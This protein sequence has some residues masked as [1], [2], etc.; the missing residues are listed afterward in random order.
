MIALDKI[1]DMFNAE[2]RNHIEITEKWTK[3]YN[4]GATS[5]ELFPLVIESHRSA[6][7]IELLNELIQAHF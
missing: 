1:N 4:N 2:S 6:A 5:K 7:K 3:A